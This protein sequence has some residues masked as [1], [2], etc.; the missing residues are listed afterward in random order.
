M[1]KDRRLNFLSSDRANAYSSKDSN[2][3]KLESPLPPVG[4]EKEWEEARCPICMEHPHNSVLLLCSSRDK[5]CRPYMCDTSNRHSN[6]LDQFCKSA[7]GVSSR[8]LQEHINIARMQ[9][10]GGRAEQ[11]L[12]RPIRSTLG[13]V[14]E[15]L[16]PLCRGKISGWVVVED[17]R[18]YMNCKARSCALE[19]CN[20]AGNYIQLRKHA[21]SEHPTVKPSDVDPARQSEWVRLERERDLGDTISAVHSQ[22]GYDPY[23]DDY[24]PTDLVINWTSD[25]SISFET[26]DEWSEDGDMLVDFDVGVEFTFSFLSEFPYDPSEEARISNRA[27]HGRSVRARLRALHGGGISS[28]DREN[29]TPASSG[30]VEARIIGSERA[31]GRSLNRTSR[32]SRSRSRS[33]HRVETNTRS[34]DTTPS[35][36]GPVSVRNTGTRRTA[37]A[38]RSV[39]S[40]S[41]PN[42]LQLR[43]PERRRDG[44]ESSRPGSGWTRNTRSPRIGSRSRPNHHRGE[45]QTTSNGRQ[46]TNTSS[47]RSASWRHAE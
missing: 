15:L 18:C 24:S 32:R 14:P 39:S 46:S 31:S 34:W 37:V 21:R 20:F 30:S 44:G 25:G 22:F 3:E 19:S 13:Q 23:V 5:G 41:R 33:N 6:C 9:Y 1:P 43:S 35:I 38:G 45:T 7:S 16:C 47:S 42:H 29:I 8:E 27:L 12:S 17:A 40:R 28:P 10:P 11:T 26:E 36:S 2:H 4:D